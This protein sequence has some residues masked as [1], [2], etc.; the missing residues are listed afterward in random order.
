MDNHADTHCFGSNFWLLSFTSEECTVSPFPP[1]YTEQ[2]NLPICTGVTGL[3][4]DSGQVLILEFGQG[5]WFGNRMEKSLIDPN[6]YKK[7][8]I[9]VCDDPTSWSFHCHW[10]KKV[11]WCLNYQIPMWISRVIAYF[12]PKLFV[13]VWVYQWFFHPISKPEALSKLQY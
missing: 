5:L 4:L 9:K 3:T 12:N 6:Q 13:L 1:E 2:I 11:F 10:D 8:G 7:F